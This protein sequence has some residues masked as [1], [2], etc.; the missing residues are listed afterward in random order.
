MR[1]QFRRDSSGA[2]ATF[3]TILAEAELG[4]DRTVKRFKIGDGITTWQNLPWYSTGEGGSGGLVDS[5]NGQIGTVILD[6]EDV[7]AATT[8]HSHTINDVAGLLASLDGKQPAGSYATGAQGL[9]ANSAVQPGDLS[10]VA[11]SGSYSDLSDKPT[12]PNPTDFATA[13]QGS[14]ADSAVQ[15]EDLSTV[16]TTGAYSDLSDKPTIPNPELFATADQGILA[17]SAV[18]PEELATVATT[19]SYND[20]SDNPTIPNPTDFA[21]AAQGSLADSAVQPEELA[22]VATTGEYSDLSGSPTI[23]NPGDFATAAQGVL[24]DSAVQPGDLTTALSNRVINVAGVA[25]IWA[26]TQAAYDL[27]T[28]D[29][30]TLYVITEP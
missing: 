27:L 13:A 29:A 19:G 24:A 26:G 23:P 11:T 14:L 18:Q 3:N 30:S 10:T 17:D 12:I 2:W 4:W 21:T 16:A 20:L 1:I 28:P 15:P 6:A 5:V 9:L 22:A 25:G 8:S 7:G